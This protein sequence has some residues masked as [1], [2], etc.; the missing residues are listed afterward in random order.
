M[1]RFCTVR[2]TLV[3]LHPFGTLFN[4]EEQRRIMARL[5][6]WAGPGWYCYDG[7]YY[8]PVPVYIVGN[9]LNMIHL[10]QN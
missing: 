6:L 4:E 5:I 8:R 9:V 1:N 3:H 7:S 2:Q 10:V